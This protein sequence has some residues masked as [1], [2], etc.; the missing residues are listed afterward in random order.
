MSNNEMAYREFVVRGRVYS[1]NETH[2][3]HSVYWS[4]ANSEWSDQILIDGIE[5]NE[6]E[7]QNA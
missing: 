7:N 1:G 6:R 3:K 5:I 4:L 2:A